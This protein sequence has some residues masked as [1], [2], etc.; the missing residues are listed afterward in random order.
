MMLEARVGF[1]PTNDGF[2]DHSLRPL[3]YRAFVAM[4]KIYAQIYAQRTQF[5]PIYT[6]S[7]SRIPLIPHTGCVPEGFCRP[8]PWATWVPRRTFEYSKTRANT[9]GCCSRLKFADAQSL[10]LNKP[11]VGQGLEQR[12]N[13]GKTA[14]TVRPAY[15]SF[16]I[17]CFLFF[18][19]Q[20]RIDFCFAQETR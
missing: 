16:T 7:H 10:S 9:G 1:E 3:G 8:L 13:T 20:G 12:C 6:Q 18:V 4:P 19:H 2:A 14:S 17:S 11:F 5:S 15:F